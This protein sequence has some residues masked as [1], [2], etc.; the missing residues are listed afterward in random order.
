MQRVWEPDDLIE[1]WTLTPEDLALLGAK[2]GHN[3]LSCAL[4]RTYLQLDGRFTQRV[5][6]A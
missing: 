5:P 3:H 1:H 4:V 2:T 6:A